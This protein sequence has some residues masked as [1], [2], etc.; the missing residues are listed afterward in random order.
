MYLDQYRHM[1][2]DMATEGPL[3][4]VT[5]NVP[6]KLLKEAMKASKVGLTDTLVEGL[7]L[8]RRRRA[9]EKALALRGKIKLHIDLD[10]ARERPHH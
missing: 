2:H 6:A 3:R 5:A 9:Y 8:V 10:Q 1:N 4:R 7:R